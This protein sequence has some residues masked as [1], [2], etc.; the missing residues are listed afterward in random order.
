MQ[1]A[2]TILPLS[3]RHCCKNFITIGGWGLDNEDSMAFFSCLS[4]L[5]S[6]DPPPKKKP[7]PLFSKFIRIL[8]FVPEDCWHFTHAQFRC[9]FRLTIPT[10]PRFA[11]K[12]VFTGRARGRGFGAK[13]GGI[14]ATTRKSSSSSFDRSRYR[15]H[16]RSLSPPR[17]RPTTVEDR[18]G[19]K[20]VD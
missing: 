11:F 15:D 9:N 13:G 12:M 6:L 16:D 2:L 7:F 18:L 14:H 8:C 5:S 20:V 1:A 19:T 17:K 10:S 4:R 3:S